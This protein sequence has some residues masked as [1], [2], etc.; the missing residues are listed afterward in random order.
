MNAWRSLKHVEYT[1]AFL[2]AGI[3]NDLF[4]Q[5]DHMLCDDIACLWND[6]DMSQR[7][8][9]IGA[10]VKERVENG[11]LHSWLQYRDIGAGLCT[12]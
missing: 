5:Q 2:N 8:K 4:G 10:W 3:A 6:F 12:S 11:T 9:D 1:A 7:R